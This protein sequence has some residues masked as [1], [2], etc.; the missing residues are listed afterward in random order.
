MAVVLDD[1]AVLLRVQSVV[2][3]SVG[4]VERS[5]VRVLPFLVVDVGLL[6]GDLDPF[7]VDLDDDFGVV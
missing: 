4:D 5:G 2:G 1:E 3:V 7:A 6:G